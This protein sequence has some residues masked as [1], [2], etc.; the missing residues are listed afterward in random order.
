[1]D[2]R[3]RDSMVA[4]L[5][6]RMEEYGIKPEDLASILASD[7]PKLKDARYRNATGDVWS[8]EGEMPQWLKQAISAGQSL[9]HFESSSQAA[10]PQTGKAVDWRNDPFAGSP[11]ARRHGD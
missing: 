6:R 2:E 1:M 11:L 7:Q 10:V 9:E 5:R 3:K 8:G 4:Y